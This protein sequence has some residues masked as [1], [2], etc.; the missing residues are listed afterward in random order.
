M[1]IYNRYSQEL[2]FY[3]YAYIRSVTTKNGA[4]GSPYY[5]GKG[6]FKRAYDLHETI[7]RP[8][9]KRNIQ[10]LYSNMNE[11]DAFQAEILLI[12]KYGRIDLGTGCLRN[13][14]AGGEGCRGGRWINPPRTSET[15]LSA[16][17]KTLNRITNHDIEPSSRMQ[18]KSC[19]GAAS[20]LSSQDVLDLREICRHNSKIL[21][22]DLA[23]QF[24]ISYEAVKD[25]RFGRTW[26][27]LLTFD[28]LRDVQ[29]PPN[30]KLTEVDIYQIRALFSTGKY[31]M[32]ELAKTYHISANCL[33]K[34]ILRLTWKFI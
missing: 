10:I 34:I 2:I 11:A 21:S 25:I 7:N 22:T 9:D 14:T 5:V 3:V 30:A 32:V 13:K 19:R 29:R 18:L 27:H 26:R 17:T 33:R 1:N 12:A 31:S 24:K 6:A 8:V 4:I 28:E 23:K 20:K 16:A 15:I